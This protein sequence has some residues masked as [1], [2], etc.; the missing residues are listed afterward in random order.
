MKKL[1]LKTKIMAF[2]GS[3]IIIMALMMWVSQIAIN[4]LNDRDKLRIVASNF[5][6]SSKLRFQYSKFRKTEYEKEFFEKMKLVDSILSEYR[7]DEKIKELIYQKNAYERSFKEFV[8]VMEQRGLNEN[9]GIEG[10]FRNSVHAIEHIIDGSNEYAMMNDMLQAR[11]SEKDFIMRSR[12]EYVTKVEKAIN[13]LVLH[14][15]KLIRDEELK[16]K[17]INL[18]HGYFDEFTSLVSIYRKLDRMQSKIENNEISLSQNLQ[19]IVNNKAA[20]AQNME[21]LLVVLTALAVIAAILLSLLISNLITKPVKKLRNIAQKIASGDFSE[22]PIAESQ[23]EIGELVLSFAEV[24]STIQSLVHEAKF[25]TDSA[26]VGKTSVRGNPDKFKGSYKNIIVGFN[27]T[28]DNVIKPLNLA[29]KYIDN[30]SKGNIPDK[31]TENL[32]GDFN[33]LKNNLNI[34]INAINA[35]LDDAEMLAEAAKNEELTKRADSGK[36][37]GDFAKLING[38]NNTL[39]RIVEKVHWYESILD[40]IPFPISVTDN[41]RNWTFLNH[42]AEELFGINREKI[43]TEQEFNIDSTDIINNSGAKPYRSDLVSFIKLK[44]KDRDYKTDA[45]FLTNLKGETIGH[46]EV[47]QDITESNKNKALQLEMLN[48]LEK[49]TNYQNKNSEHLT[50]VLMKMADGNFDL[51]LEIAECDKDTEHIRIMFEKIA[52]ALDKSI[53]AVRLLTDDSNSLAFAALEGNLGY[54]TGIERHFGEYKEIVFS[55]NNTVRSLIEPINEASGILEIM[56]TGDLT[57]IM[58]GNYKGDFKKLAESINDVIFSLNEL[59]TEVDSAVSSVALAAGE[60]N[61][62]TEALTVGAMDQKI[63]TQDVAIA[64]EQMSS[65]VTENARSAHRTSDVARENGNIAQE[66]ARVME[67]TIAKMHD[68]AAVV[69]TS[70]NNIQKL[71]ESGKRIS[72][73]LSVIDEI[74]DQTNLLALNAAIEAARAGEHGRGFAVVADEVRKLAER[75]TE[76]TKQ[77]ETMIHGIQQETETAVRE[78]IKGTSEVSEGIQLADKAGESLKQILLSSETVLEMVDQITAASADQSQTSS[79]I[80]KS[81]ASIS[82]LASDSTEKI[83][84]IANASEKLRTLTVELTQAM[85]RFKVIRRG[86][87]HA[88]YS[89]LKQSLHLPAKSKLLKEKNIGKYISFG[90]KS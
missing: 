73:I 38:V 25:L 58:E 85:S 62:A 47:V 15:G 13:N 60:I 31:I 35:L 41:N 40:S 17:I 18:A 12:T 2:G 50:E 34:C 24:K 20:T 83:T 54:R 1:S 21:F 84:D 27:Q 26:S 78:M 76:A 57:Q 75:T 45:A 36:H 42:S 14:T 71:G 23:D 39:D 32:E 52:K 33:E 63:Q 77:I 89:R 82:N 10:N 79:E 61:T 88:H 11:R 81:V 53:A 49:I 22:E 86:D 37:F 56:S 9:L 7:N 64:V 48:K 67:E 90:S 43:R 8:A 74:A 80:A 29:A 59:I 65:T 3:L 6:E 16:T 44:N 5:I 87:S 19:D 28:M 68:I 51:K 66:G 69:K 46:V 72:E 4:K 70:A 55:I 30:I